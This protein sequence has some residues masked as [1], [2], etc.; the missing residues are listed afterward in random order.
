MASSANPNKVAA[1]QLNG[2]RTWQENQPLLERLVHD[3]ARAGAKIAVLPENLYAMAASPE[4]WRALS[5]RM[6]DPAVDWL[7][8]LARRHGIWL[9]AGT[10]PIRDEAS[11]EKVW[12]RSLVFDDAGAI[13]GKYDKIHLFDVDLPGRTESYRESDLFVPGDT[14]VVIDTPVGPLGMSICFDLR[15]P[16]LYRALVD[17]GAR[18]VCLPAAFT[19]ATGQAH[20]HSLIR[21]RAIEN[22]VYMVA[23]AQ[24]GQHADGR[25]TY[26]HS[27]IVDPW[28]G[29]MADAGTVAD[30]FVTGSFDPKHQDEI[31]QRFPVLDLRRL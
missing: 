9:V 30:T 10:L 26:G 29:I 5:V 11:G 23:S 13:R 27:L 18:W 17:A 28:G 4:E 1:I 21:S 25:R 14:P 7:A 2:R 16:E 15:F 19:E 6:T 31:R 20:W 24:V 8:D 12:A 22:S 3:A